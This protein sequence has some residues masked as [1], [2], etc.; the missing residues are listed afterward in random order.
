MSIFILN[1]QANKLLPI[2][3]KGISVLKRLSH[4]QENGEGELRQGNRGCMEKQD[5]V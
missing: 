1:I 2:F 4:Q 5:N 3:T